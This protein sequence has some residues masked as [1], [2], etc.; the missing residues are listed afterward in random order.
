[1]SPKLEKTISADPISPE[2]RSHQNEEWLSWN[3]K[4]NPAP[5][6]KTTPPRIRQATPPAL[7]N[8]PRDCSGASSLRYKSVI[9]RKDRWRPVPDMSPAEIASMTVTGV[10]LSGFSDLSTATATASPHRQLI[11][12]VTTHHHH[13]KSGVGRPALT[14]TPRECSGASFLRYQ[15][16]IQRKD[17]WRPIPD[18]SPA[19]I[20]SMN[21]TGVGLSGLSDFS[22]AAVTLS[23]HRKLIVS[24]TTHHHHRKSGVGRF[25]GTGDALSNAACPTT[26]ARPIARSSS[27]STWG[28]CRRPDPARELALQTHLR[29]SLEG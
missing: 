3:E 26:H 6:T 19:E 11:V 4:S 5:T 2:A 8:T 16:V 22:T 23:P 14:N 29:D 21:A 27:A 13:R 7:T 24:V 1:M 25:I 10:R 9:Q 17:R 15:S 12:S 18:M 20:A 28:R